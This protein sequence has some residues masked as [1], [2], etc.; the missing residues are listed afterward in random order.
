MNPTGNLRYSSN[1]PIA[2]KMQENRTKTS[3]Q[4]VKILTW[5]SVEKGSG[6]VDRTPPG[7]LGLFD[8]PV[9]PSPTL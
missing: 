8:A 9:Y 5:K 7:G 4:G 1:Q 2:R 3:K 6:E